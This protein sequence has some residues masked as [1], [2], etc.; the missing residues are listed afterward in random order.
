MEEQGRKGGG[1]ERGADE[2]EEEARER[3]TTQPCRE[4]RHARRVSLALP[5]N[6]ES[7]RR[8]ALFFFFL[9][10]FFLFILNG[11]NVPAC[12]LSNQTAADGKEKGRGLR[13]VR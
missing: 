10:F 1:N 13:N 9:S 5:T 7:C 12:S 6:L 11:V 2:G 8:N 4:A 3:E